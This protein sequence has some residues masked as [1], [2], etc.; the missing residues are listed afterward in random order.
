MRR[1]LLILSLLVVSGGVWA[2]DTSA[3]QP[4]EIALT[5][6]VDV[7]GQLVLLAQGMLTNQNADEAYTNISLFADVYDS[8]GTIIGEG[9]GY[10]VDECGVALTDFA[11][12]PAASHDFM[13]TLELYEDGTTPDRVEVTAEGSVTEV[14]AEDITPLPNSIEQVAS[15]EVVAL[16]WVDAISLRYGVG[17]ANRVFTELEWHEFNLNTG[18]DVEITHPNT[19]R[20]TDA[21]LTQTDLAEP[22]YYEHSFLT[23]SPTSRR[24]VYQTDLSAFVSAEPDGSYKRILYDDELFRH[25]LQGIL[26]QPE[27]VFLAYYFGAYG[28]TVLYFTGTADGQLL[29]DSIYGNPPSLIVPGLTPDGRQIVIAVTVDDVTGYYLKDSVYDNN[30]L[31]FEGDAPGN[32]YP[33]PIYTE[34]ESGDYIY[35]VRVVDEQPTLQ[36]FDVQTSTLHDLVSLPLNLTTE[37]RAWTWLS[38]DGYTLALGA[39][40][41]NSGLWLVDLSAFDV[42]Q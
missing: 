1:L 20:V 40:G 11:L 34:H 28:E 23:F 5:Q 32:N 14:A 15:D 2:Q 22:G 33:A 19:E 3:L 25:S 17:C 18:L 30:E 37:Q 42:C 8:A 29:S 10:L 27:G 41:T 6:G 26:W 16:E 21:L 24:I 31:L 12:Q 36:C 7:Y 35:L 39:N 4:E 38:P 9:F 13:I